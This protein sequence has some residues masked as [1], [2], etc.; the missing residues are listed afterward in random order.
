[1]IQRLLWKLTLKYLIRQLKSAV[2]VD[3][4]PARS[5]LDLHAL[6]VVRSP[7]LD[8]GQP[9]FAEPPQVVDPY[10]NGSGGRGA[11]ASVAFGVLEAGVNEKV[12][13][14]VGNLKQ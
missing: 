6:L 2:K 4:N 13:V 1:M 10:L 11:I 5:L 12:L 8:E 7:S 3:L 9:Q 14:V